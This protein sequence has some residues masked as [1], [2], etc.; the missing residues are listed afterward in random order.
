[1]DHI[2]RL[3]VAALIF[4]TIVATVLFAACSVQTKKNAQGKP[5]TVDIK[6]PFG[7]THI[8]TDPNA[9]TTGFSVYP[10]SRPHHENDKN[11][12]SGAV[13]MSMFGMNLAVAAFDTDDPPQKV[14]EF[15]D[16]QVKKYGAVLHCQ[17]RGGV[18]TQGY[19]RNGESPTVCEHGEATDITA[20][21]NGEG[22]ELKAG[23]TNDQHMV[24]IKSQGS[25]TQYVLLK[26][27]HGKQ[28]ESI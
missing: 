27:Q 28:G 24:V 3:N 10:G 20:A 1:M 22:I 6:T 12:S 26:L 11:N 8:E 19:G 5:E 13:N 2:K 18:H 23:T 14:F 4:V 17:V 21:L 9:Q 16:P 7:S 15:Y 25:G